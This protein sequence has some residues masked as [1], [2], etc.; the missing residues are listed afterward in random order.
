MI[1]TQAKDFESA[2]NE[3]SSQ[4]RIVDN[5]IQ[6]GLEA[7]SSSAALF[8]RYRAKLVRKTQRAVSAEL[9]LIFNI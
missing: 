1:G 8:D 3:F 5:L 9:V 4:S 6:F 7:M 2:A